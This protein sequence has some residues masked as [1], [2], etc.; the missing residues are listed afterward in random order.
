MNRLIA[1]WRRH[2][3]IASVFG[4]ALALTVFFAFRAV[5]FAI[6]WSDPA[7]R[8]QPIEGW[9]TPRY[10][11]HSWHLPREVMIEVLGE[12]PMP[13][14]RR[15]RAEIARDRG[16]PVEVLVGELSAAIDAFRI[17]SHD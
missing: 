16:V 7:H 12:G 1:I 14:K 17:G 2:K 8:D 5:I 15:T 6:Y 9:M 13:G 10:V 4:L 11:A 3:V